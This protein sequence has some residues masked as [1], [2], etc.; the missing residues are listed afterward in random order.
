[1][2]SKLKTDV[3]ETVSGS[4]TI[5]LTNQLSGM[6]SASVPLL[7]HAQ[8]PSGSVIQVV[9]TGS[10]AT[11]S[12]SSTSFVELT[13]LRVSIT[14]LSANSNILVTMN[15]AKQGNQAQDMYVVTQI[16]SSLDNYS[17]SLLTNVT[18]FYPTWIQTQGTDMVLHSAGQAA[19]TTINYRMYARSNQSSFYAPDSWGQGA[20]SSTVIQEIKG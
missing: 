17:S 9:G 6:T 16:R 18:A 15:V 12:S 10:S 14:T 2:T 1:M 19:G 5:A 20:H 7:T 8:M 3:L 4:G 11:F 13:H